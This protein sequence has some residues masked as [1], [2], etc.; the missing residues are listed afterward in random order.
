MFGKMF[1]KASQ[2][3][4]KL[5][6]ATDIDYSIKVDKI[7]AMRKVA[8]LEAERGNTGYAK[9]ADLYE[10]LIQMSRH[11]AMRFNSNAM[12]GMDG[13]TQATFANAEARFRAMD[14]MRETDGRLTHVSWIKSLTKNTIRCSTK[15]VF[16]LTKL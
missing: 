13:M 10:N 16:L 6:T 4:P 12:T 3:D 9:L 1:T 15:A 7:D 14:L 8:K 11:P 2:N 5:Q